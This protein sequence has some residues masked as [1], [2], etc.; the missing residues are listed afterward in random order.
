MV[1]LIG[2][3]SLAGRMLAAYMAAKVLYSVRL[4]PTRSVPDESP[5]M[6]TF[7]HSR[8]SAWE[9]RVHTVP[10]GNLL[11]SFPVMLLHSKKRLVTANVR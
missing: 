9:F 11:Y 4:R 7:P 5:R 2:C 3:V 8:T 10:D 6:C 1:Y